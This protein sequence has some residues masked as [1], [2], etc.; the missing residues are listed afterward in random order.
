MDL[1]CGRSLLA[2]PMVR[3]RLIPR[4]MMPALIK[5][6]PLNWNKWFKLLVLLQVSFLAFLGPFSQGAIVC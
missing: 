1:L 6:D 5:T 3:D 4:E 2:I